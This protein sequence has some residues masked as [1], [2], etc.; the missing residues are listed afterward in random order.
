VASV[1]V[2]AFK[3]TPQLAPN[4]PQLILQRICLGFH[5]LEFGLQPG[6]LTA[7][8]VLEFVQPARLSGGKEWLSFVVSRS[9]PLSALKRHAPE[10]SHVL[11]SGS[12]AP[13][14]SA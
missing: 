14:T 10:V 11:P 13:P 4:L 8:R 9:N 1:E 2:L 6:L 12:L 5:L 7:G 3:P